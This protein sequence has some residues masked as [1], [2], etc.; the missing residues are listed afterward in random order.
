[1]STRRQPLTTDIA[2][3]TSEDIKKW[4]DFLFPTDERVL[5]E[6]PKDRKNRA[7]VIK[8]LEEATTDAD[9]FWQGLP[10]EWLNRE[11][12]PKVVKNKNKKST[13]TLRWLLRL[14]F[15]FAQTG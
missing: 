10:Q 15:F 6:K 11:K 2:H 7:K 12:L 8:E 9:K 14:C 13:P 3:C 4:L 1:M 5:N